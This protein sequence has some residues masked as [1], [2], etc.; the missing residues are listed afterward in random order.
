ME[1]VESVS[2]SVVSN[3]LQPH[4][5]YSLLGSSVHEILQARILEWLQF[6][7][8]GDPPDPGMEPGSPALQAD[9]SPFV[10]PGKPF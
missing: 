2:S 7:S 6:S 10:P 8:P 4:I 1:N 5:L 3:C 9:S